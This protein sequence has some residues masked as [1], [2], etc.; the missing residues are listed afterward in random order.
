MGMSWCPPAAC[1]GRIDMSKPSMKYTIREIEEK[2]ILSGGLLEV[3]ENVA[4]VGD[5]DKST[6]KMIL[7]DIKSNP[8]HRIF[9][10]V[11]EDGTNQGLIVGTTTLIVEPKFIL[12]GGRVGHIEDVAVR[13]EYQSKGIRFELVSHATEQ[14][15]IMGCVRTILDCSNE[16]V[17]FYEKVG[18]SYYGNCMKIEYG[19]RLI[20]QK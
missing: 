8:L 14:A 11:V 15:A 3:L 20:K 18:Y 5:L 9:V 1:D 17:P 10:A 16:N 2:D 13:S 6:A 12:G 19:A 4:P 7:K